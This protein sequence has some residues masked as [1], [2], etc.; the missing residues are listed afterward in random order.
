MNKLYT[1][2]LTAL[3][4]GAAA[5]VLR[6]LQN[7][8]G[9][10]PDTGLPIPGNPAGMALAALLVLLAAAFFF[11][12][13]RLPQEEAG[14]FVFPADFSTDKPGLLAVPMAG[15]FLIALSGLVD[16]S[17]CLGVLP[18]GIGFSQHALYGVLREGGMGF[19][20]RG[21]ALL[22][23]LAI[24][25]A[26]G[27]FLALA[28]CRRKPEGTVT[29]SAAALVGVLMFPV[30]AMVIRL[31]LTYRVDSVNPSTEMYYLEL[32]ALVFMTLSFYRLS[33][34]ACQSGKTDRFGLYASAASVLCM[35]CLAD[36]GAYLSSML[37]FGGGWLTLMGFLLLRLQKIEQSQA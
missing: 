2:P 23:I 31:V 19:S 16:L 24:A 10:E 34:F 17:E 20:P 21:Q 5:Y 1:L 12:I 37:M 36:G 14:E 15:V 18:E 35:A 27:L 6:M 33:S 32:L 25:S 7:R 3:L 11:L 30:A 29:L 8:T 22:G 28:A 9:F 4:G 26:A 13:R